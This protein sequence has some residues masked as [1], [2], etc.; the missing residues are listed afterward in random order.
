MDKSGHCIIQTVKEKEQDDPQMPSIQKLTYVNTVES[1]LA[2][3][4]I[5]CKARKILKIAFLLN[6]QYLKI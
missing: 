6:L 3:N 5:N 4:I 2:I 1:H